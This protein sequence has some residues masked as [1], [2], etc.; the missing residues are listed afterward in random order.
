MVGREYFGDG[1]RK[2]FEDRCGEENEERWMTMNQGHGTINLEGG[3]GQMHP[4]SGKVTG[5]GRAMGRA[6]GGDCTVG[7]LRCM[8][9]SK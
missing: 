1:K 4:D 9:A 8:W 6:W 7:G 2:R 3:Q 5:A